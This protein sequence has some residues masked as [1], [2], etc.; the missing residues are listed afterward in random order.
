MAKPFR[1]ALHDGN[2]KSLLANPSRLQR[3]T[4][5]IYTVSAIACWYIQC[6]SNTRSMLYIPTCPL[7][8]LVWAFMG[9]LP[10]VTFLILGLLVPMWWGNFATCD[11]TR[12]YLFGESKIVNF[13]SILRTWIKLYKTVWKSLFGNNIDLHTFPCFVRVTPDWNNQ[14]KISRALQSL[15]YDFESDLNSRP[16][17]LSLLV[18]SFGVMSATLLDGPVG[19]TLFKDLLL[20]FIFFVTFQ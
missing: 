17:L 5:V 14:R 20:T 7:Y 10:F 15:G 8:V 3:N 12:H 9:K 2:C 18:I 4:L 19:E 13:G 11:E 6:W 1:P 16:D